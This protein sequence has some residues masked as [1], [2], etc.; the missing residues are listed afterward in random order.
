M[1]EP[2]TRTLEEAQTLLL[3][4]E[5][6][7]RN[8]GA[9]AWDIAVAPALTYMEQALQA[10]SRVCEG[11]ACSIVPRGEVHESWAVRFTRAAASW[12]VRPGGM[13]PSYEQQVRLMSSLHEAA[14]TL[15]VAAEST[16][17]ARDMV[18]AEVP[19]ASRMRG[20]A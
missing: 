14:A 15:R 5:S 20:A 12:P 18:A 10:L 16:A 3:A 7:E 19:P 13:P 17:H 4:A 8:I 1:D 6:L 11:A 2:V 9:P